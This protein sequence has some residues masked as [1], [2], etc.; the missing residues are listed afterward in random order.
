MAT[1]RQE[2]N[3]LAEL[4]KGKLGESSQYFQFC[5]ECDEVRVWLN[6]KTKVAS[7]E[8][9]RVR[10][11]TGTPEITPSLVKFQ[12]QFGGLTKLEIMNSR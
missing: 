5:R 6:E 2:L 9:Y 4:R 3:K 12:S 10:D 7:D 8:S 11:F 1:K